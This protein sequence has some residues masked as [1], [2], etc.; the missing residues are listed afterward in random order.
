MTITALIVARAVCRDPLRVGMPKHVRLLAILTVGMHFMSRPNSACYVRQ[1]S[2]W[3]EP[4]FC[5]TG[6]DAG[7]AQGS[8]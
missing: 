1:C 2:A 4:R 5:N 3:H 6:K 8:T 7:K